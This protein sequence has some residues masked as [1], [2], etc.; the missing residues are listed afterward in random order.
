MQEPR[1]KNAGDNIQSPDIN[2]LLRALIMGMLICTGVRLYSALIG[3]IG[4]CVKQR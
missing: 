4:K 3:V 1:A 2:K